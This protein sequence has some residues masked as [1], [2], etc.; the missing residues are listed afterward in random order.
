MSEK[1]LRPPKPPRPDNSRKFEGKGYPPRTIQQPRTPN[2]D[3]YSNRILTSEKTLRA[4]SARSWLKRAAVLA[5]TAGALYGVERTVS[6]VSTTATNPSHDQAPTQ[7][8][9]TQTPVETAFA[10]T[11]LIIP[12]DTGESFASPTEITPTRYSQETPEPTRTLESTRTPTP[13]NTTEPT[14]TIEPSNTPSPTQT[15]EATS[16]PSPTQTPE[17][18]STPEQAAVQEN[19]ILLHYSAEGL[20]IS[21]TY[22]TRTTELNLEA[23]RR[24]SE[25]ARQSGLPILIEQFFIEPD[26]PVPSQLTPEISEVPDDIL[27][28]EQLHEYNVEIIQTDTT[29]LSL[30]RSAFEPGGVLYEHTQSDFQLI[31]ALVDSPVIAPQFLHDERYDRIRH[32]LDYQH[33]SSVEDWL[34]QEQREAQENL[35]RIEHQL[36]TTNS[37]ESS[38]VRIV[39]Q[40]NGETQEQAYVD[41]YLTN[42]RLD[43]LSTDD[44]EQS[45]LNSRIEGVFFRPSRQ[46]INATTVADNQER[47][48]TAVIFLAVGNTVPDQ[49]IRDS[50]GAV[51]ANPDGSFDTVINKPLMRSAAPQNWQNLP[52]ESDYQLYPET[53][54]EG[55]SVRGLLGD[56]HGPGFALTHELKHYGELLSDPRKRNLSESYADTEALAEIA[57]AHRHL[58][59]TGDSSLYPFIFSYTD[60]DTHAIKYIRSKP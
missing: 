5:G 17:A 11:G 33:I 3:Q 12:T 13:T 24:A 51:F 52:S 19:Q 56:T 23:V 32:L 42:L 49:Y 28:P 10:D 59:Q 53:T 7:L 25:T 41:R 36:Q 16:T 48:P 60:P 8:S 39:M 58:E 37:N 35:E 1:N 46:N 45:G 31:I 26:Q 27:T 6:S 55:Y 9:L 50:I 29:K 44:V 18:T 15:P 30:A 54:S 38:S 34:S 43:S 21:Y 2:R 4:S 14:S 57:A 22:N 47:Q 20:P 40:Y